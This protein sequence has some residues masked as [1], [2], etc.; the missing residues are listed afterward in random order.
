MHY[1]HKTYIENYEIFWF[2]ITNVENDYCYNK[3]QWNNFIAFAYLNKYL[4]Y[5]IFIYWH[6]LR[7][8]TKRTN[9]MKVT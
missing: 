6:R 9:N 4:N 7:K 8:D 3:K 5:V 2:A 1:F